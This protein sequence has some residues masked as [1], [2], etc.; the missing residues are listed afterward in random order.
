MDRIVEQISTASLEV[1]RVGH[2]PPLLYLHGDRGLHH[3]QLAESLAMGFQ[4]LAPVHPGWGDLPAPND[5]DSIGD[6]AELYLEYLN[7]NREHLDGPIYVVGVSVGA[8]IAA[9][10]AS[11][12]GT[13]IAGIVLVSPIGLKIG[14]RDERD[15]VDIYVTDLEAIPAVMYGSIGQ[16]D[17]LHDKSSEDFLATARA[18]EGMARYTWQP[19]LNDPKLGRRMQRITAPTLVIYGT[20]DRLV[21][22]PGYFVDFAA[23]IGSG[24]R[25]HALDGAG[26]RVDEELPND[27]AKLASD[28]LTQSNE[29]A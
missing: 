14:P 13:R 10:L 17:Y 23:S 19:Y 11:L 28:F 12:A 25:S 16:N 6:I 5:F 7:R 15:F 8:W 24:A 20:E 29:V 1:S 21:T 9:H 22:R 27:V 2:G 18:E 3:D 26:H 4:V